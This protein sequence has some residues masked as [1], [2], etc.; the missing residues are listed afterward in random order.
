LIASPAFAASQGSS[1]NAKLDNALNAVADA[2]DRAGISGALSRAEERAVPTRPGGLVSVILES[3]EGVDTTSIDLDEVARRGGRVDAVSRSFIRVLVPYGSLRKLADHPGVGLVRI[4]TPAVEVG[5]GSNVSE[6]V[7][8]TGAVA[9]QASGVSGAGVSVGVVDLGFTGLSDAIAAGE[10]PGGT[11]VV[12][13]TGTGAETDTPHGTGVAEHVMDM[14]PSATLYCLKVSDEVDLQNAADYCAANGIAVANHSVGWVNASYYDGT[15]PINSIINESRTDDVFWSVAAGND[16]QRHWR[17]VWKDD[18]SDSFL[19]FSG[20]DE[21]LDLTSS[22][23]VGYVFLNWDQYGNSLTDLDLYVVDKR[24]RVVASSTG[25]QTGAQAPAEAVAFNYVFPKAPYQIQVKH[26]SGATTDL[27]VT[28]FS[29]YN[30]LEYAVAASSL[31]DPANAPGAFSV[32]AVDQ[33][34]WNSSPPPPEPYSSQGPTNDGRQKPDITAPDGTTSW[35]YGPEASFGTSFSAPTTAG[36]A[37]LLLSQDLGRTAGDLEG[38]LRTTAEDVG[39]PGWDPVYGYGKLRLEAG[40]PNTPPQANDDGPF[41]VAEDSGSTTLDVLAN[42]SDVDGD[43]LS[44]ASVSDPGHGIASVIDGGAAISY[45]PDPDYFGTDSFTYSVSDGRGGIDPAAVTIEV[46]P[47][48][49]APVADAQAVIT[50]QDTPVEITLNGSDVDGDPLTYAVVT[51]PQ[52]GVL[53]GTA[54][55]LTYE[56][57]PGYSGPDAF[58]F[59]VNDGNGG[60]DTATV[61]ITVEPPNSPPNASFTSAATDLTV[62]FTDTSSDTDGSVV[63]WHWDLGDGDTSS[64]QHPGHTYAAAGDYTVTLTVTDDDGAEDSVAQV[65]TVTA[66]TIQPMHVGDIAMALRKMGRNW[67]AQATVVV[68]DGSGGFV[69]AA[70]VSGDWYFAGSAIGSSS[71]STEADGTVTLRSPKKKAN[72]GDVFSFTVTDIQKNGYVYDASQNEETS[73]SITVP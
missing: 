20:G 28:L 7:S 4:P 46:T 36:G 62:D 13:F 8:L 69:G 17:G 9:L 53:S 29:F 25:V 43:P 59:E 66:P 27:D 73:D 16:A 50:Q 22:S 41:P 39:D 1:G 2:F 68:V 10:L 56:P 35:T 48:N 18:D 47:V 54:P 55:L 65:V 12:D 21:R 60:T 31:M 6:S 72:P 37:A 70:T 15:G 30:D 11:V 23:S 49:D 5:F 38:I 42:D 67:E 14:A 61:S 63:A 34:D 57:N 45:A 64:E 44:V 40:P 19:E 52:N 24:G 58:T 32:A 33:V 3:Q 71:G 26:Y 51:P